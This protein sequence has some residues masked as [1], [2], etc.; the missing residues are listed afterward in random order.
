M[1]DI[2]FFMLIIA[3]YEDKSVE[4]FSLSFACL[5]ELDFELKIVY[6]DLP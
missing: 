2:T 4:L 1:R 6:L 5:L 3:L